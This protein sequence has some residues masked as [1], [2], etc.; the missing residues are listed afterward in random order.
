MDERIIG[1]WEKEEFG[2]IINII[3]INPPKM[4]MSIRVTGY[5]N[6]EP[7]CAYE[8]DG[9]FCYEINDINN[10]MVYHVKYIDGKL[11]GYYTFQ[12]HTKDVTYEKVSDTPDDE[13]YEYNPQM[14]LVPGTNKTRIEVLKEFSK[15]DR[16]LKYNITNTFVLGGKVPDI[17][18]K[19]NYNNYIKNL[20]NTD[21]ELAFAILNFVCDNFGHNGN[22]GLGQNRTITDIIMFCEEH[23]QKTNCRGLAILLA[24]LLRLNG[25][26]AQHVTC[27]PYEDPFQDCHVVVDCLLPSGKRI[28]LDPTYRL[29]YKDKNGDYV[30]LQKLREI[31]ILGKALYPNKEASYNGGNFDK[32]HNIGYM[33][34]NTFRFSRFT[35]SKDGN[36]SQNIES[37]Y[38]ELVPLGYVD[39][40]TIDDSSYLIYNDEEFWKI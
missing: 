20:K 32:V 8:K 9:Y 35:L 2:E 23:N 10:R 11:K 39:E 33:T 27:M 25:I 1:K 31:L 38:I 3:S 16:N 4:K 30:S 5:F 19:Y 34:K 14:I 12:G 36:D 15:Y 28:M 7:N 40:T 13:A 17:L 22:I 29:Y 18:N 21:D 24:S 37:R 26:K 6:I